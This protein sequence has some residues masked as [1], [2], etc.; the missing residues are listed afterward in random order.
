[1]QK[2]ALIP[3]TCLLFGASLTCQAKQQD[4]NFWQTPTVHDYGRI[5]YLPNSAFK[6][7]AHQQY[8]IV[9]ALNQG[10]EKPDQV[11]QALDHVARTVNLYV[12]SGV[13]LKNLH[14]VA[15]AYGKATPLVLRDEEYRKKF[16]V[17]NPNLPLIDALK[18]AGVTVSVCG[19]AVAEHQFDYGWIDERVTLALSALTTITTLEQQG[20]SLMML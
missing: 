18:K 8:K 7:D 11:N 15:V 5:H 12:A 13:P 19:Q 20:Y 4:S 14:F 1:M 10:A 16:G 2:V 17:A 9:F 6:P 3:L